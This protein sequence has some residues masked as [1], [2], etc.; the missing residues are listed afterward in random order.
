MYQ[1]SSSWRYHFWSIKH[2]TTTE[3]SGKDYV[4]KTKPTLLILKNKLLIFTSQEVKFNYF[5]VSIMGCFI[6]YATT[7]LLQQEEASHGSSPVITQHHVKK[8]VFLKHSSYLTYPWFRNM[9]FNFLNDFFR[10]FSRT[11]MCSF[12]NI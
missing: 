2:F 9:D 11:Q 7:E 4:P 3:H 10:I 6:D 8:M 12:P 1:R 5:L